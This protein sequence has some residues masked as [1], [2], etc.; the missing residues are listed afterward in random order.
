MSITLHLNHEYD[1]FSSV[2]LKYSLRISSLVAAACEL[3]D[4]LY[5][6]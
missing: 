6:V 1:L 4:N 2:H 5:S 3:G